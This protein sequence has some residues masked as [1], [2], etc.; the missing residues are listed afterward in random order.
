MLRRFLPTLWL[1]ASLLTACQPV[2]TPAATAPAVPTDIPAAAPI[3]HADVIRLALVGETDLTNV[4][5]YYDGSGAAY[6][7]RAVQ[8][9]F[10]PSLFRLSP[11][12]GTFEPYLAATISPLEPDYGFLA[13]TVTL[14]ANLFWSDGSPLTA[15]DVAFT[16]NTALKFHLGLDWSAAYDADVLDHAEAINAQS[17]RFYVRTQPSIEDWQYGALQG[18]IVHAA[19]WAPKLSAAEG[20]LNPNPE[21]DQEILDLQNER[22]R[23]ERELADLLSQLA[24]LDPASAAFAE[25]NAQTYK[26]QD[27]INSLGARIEDKRAE[28]ESV[29][30]AA[31]Q[32]LYELSA[33][34]EPTFG[35][36]IPARRAADEFENVVNPYFPFTPPNFDRA[37]Y[38]VYAD[39]ESAVQALYAGDVNVVL[40]PDGVSAP[41][42]GER[43]PVPAGGVDPRKD[44]FVRSNLRVLAFNL[45]RPALADVNLRRAIVC[46]GDGRMFS[47]VHYP[48]GLIL[49]ATQFGVASEARFPCAELTLPERLA[50][51]VRILEA[52]GYAWDVKPVWDGAPRAGSGLRR[53]GANLPGLTVLV[54]QEDS[55]RIEVANMAADWM[56]VIGLDVKVEPVEASE[57]M[58]RVF[59]G[60][61]FDMTVLGWR[62]PR[63]PLYL[64]DWFGAGNPYGYQRIELAQHCGAFGSALELDAARQE[65]LVIESLLAQDLPLAPLYS[66][67]GYDLYAGITYPFANALDGLTG[68]YGAPW[69]AIPVLP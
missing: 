16:V 6:N 57:L 49:S 32:A 29:F 19:Y 47:S 69:L 37:I 50:E 33:Q 62:V 27:E 53:G 28:T 2:V 24:F 40:D 36:F 60:G 25:I 9:E 12:T 26:K 65:I 64:C 54:A 55:V 38:R 18:P 45:N 63:V 31:R 7:N 14:R 20:R 1:A 15:E 59:D 51:S 10:W 17:V 46:M 42:E 22:A 34:D 66:E 13:S 67:T 52:A 44:S 35:P 8:A 3:P 11:A 4:W 5:A 39:E 23:L 61:Q 58:V 43:L 68:M 56:R 21:L 41:R 30:A 48:D